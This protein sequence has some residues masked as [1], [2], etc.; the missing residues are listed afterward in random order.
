LLIH[1]LKNF[2]YESQEKQQVEKA[3]KA[4]IYK[5]DL[6]RKREIDQAILKCTIAAGLPFT[7]FNHNALIELLNLLEPGYK[8]PDRGTLALRIHDQYYQHILDLKSVL[9]HVGPIA[10]TSDV[11]KDVSRQHIISLSLHT[12]SI[13]YE[14]VSLPISF[15][16]FNDQKLAINIRAF[17]EYEKE[18]FGF[19]TRILSGITT[20]NGPDIRCG[21][22]SGVLGP[23]Y[24]CL[25]H[26]FNLVVHHGTCVWDLPNPK[27]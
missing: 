22:S 15:H 3:N 27:R 13:D 14:F 1:N 12:F 10:F 6:S 18:R 23:R 16:R 11:W 24:A 17:F 8:P 21:A 25:A 20:D 19:D 5:I 26:C 7:L 9:L 2:A 4:T